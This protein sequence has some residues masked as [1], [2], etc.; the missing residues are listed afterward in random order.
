MKKKLINKQDKDNDALIQGK[1]EIKRLFLRKRNRMELQINKKYDAEKKMYE[2]A[3]KKC[4]EVKKLKLRELHDKIEEEEENAIS[5]LE[6][7]IELELIV[8]RA[9][10]K[11]S[12]NQ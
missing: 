3:I 2:E 11:I 5:E 12:K 8:K 7:E 1:A 6:E 4:E 10:G 9:K